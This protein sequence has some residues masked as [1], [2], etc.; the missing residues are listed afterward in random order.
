MDETIAIESVRPMLMQLAGRFSSQFGL[1]KDEITSELLLVALLA[2]RSHNPAKRTL[3]S[4]VHLHCEQRFCAILR[5]WR[6][7]HRFERKN[8]TEKCELDSIQ[9]VSFFLRDMLFELSD[10]AGTAIKL[11][12]NEAAADRSYIQTILSISY[13]WTQQRID[14]VFNEIRE[15]L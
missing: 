2:I 14:R 11:A 7:L 13:G 9:A 12:V 1:C 8:G 3:A 15:A 5:R 6:E 10:D 4:W